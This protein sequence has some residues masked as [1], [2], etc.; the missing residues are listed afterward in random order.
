MLRIFSYLPNPRV[1]KTTITA[2]LCNIAVEV[3]GAPPADLVNWL[4]DFDARPLSD[5][6]TVS[7]ASAART[8]RIGF[9]DRP[10]YKTDAFLALQPFASV[11]AAF[12]NDGAIGLFES[13]SIMRVVARMDESGQQLYGGDIWAASRIDGFLDTALVFA[14]DTQRY[15]S[16]LRFDALTPV[17]HKDAADAAVTYL[18]GIENALGSGDGFITSG[19]LTLADIAFFCELAL[20]QNERRFRATLERTGLPL[21]FDDAALSAY[22]LVANHF[23]ALAQHPAIACDAGQYLADIASA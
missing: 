14:R 13:N 19:Q 11:P 15:L 5:E 20:C 8:G 23:A 16:A 3:R 2:R 17:I 18:G 7:L 9:V 21:I 1:W 12:S 4:W 10:L 22:P 6:D